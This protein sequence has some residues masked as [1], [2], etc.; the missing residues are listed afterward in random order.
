MTDK[1]K[2]RIV[3]DGRSME[4]DGSTNVLQAALGQGLNVPYF[5]WH[6]KLGS[7]GACRQCAVIEYK[8]ED[9][10]KG[11]IVMACMTPAREGSRISLENPGAELFRA[12]IIESVMTNHP[13]DCPTC[14]EVG[15]CHLQDMTVMTEHN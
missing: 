10:K 4:V 9:D 1:K 12:L 5:C 8:D 13:H 15:H 7:V 2:A 6:P 14:D 3:I 11:R